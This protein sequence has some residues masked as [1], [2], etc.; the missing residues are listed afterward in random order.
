MYFIQELKIH[1]N[2]LKENVYSFCSFSQLCEENTCYNFIAVLEFGTDT[3]TIFQGVP[4]HFFE[5]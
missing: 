1:R 5:Q 2:I 3:V 4:N